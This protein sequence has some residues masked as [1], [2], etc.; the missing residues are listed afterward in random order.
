MRRRHWLACSL[1]AA[2]LP[3]ARPAPADDEPVRRGRALQF[4]RDHGAHLGAA[5]EW[6]YLTG[7]LHGAGDAHFGFQIT[8]FRSRTGLAEGLDSRFAP[9]HLLFAHAALSELRTRRHRHAQRIARWSGDE[10]ATA[11]RA[12]RHDTDLRLGDWTLRRSGERGLSRYQ[13]R[14]GSGGAAGGFELQ[15]E[16]HATQPPL[17]QGDA[18][19]SRKG[20]EEAQASHYLSEPQLQARGALERGGERFGVTGRA[21]LDHEWSDTLMHPEAVGWDWIGMNLDDGAALTAFRLRRADGSSLWAGG[22]HRSAGG[23]LQV[24]APD[25]VRFTPGR[26]WTSPSS[27]ARYALQWQVDTPAGR[28][29]VEALLDAQELDSR[30]GTGTVYW[31]GLAELRTAPQRRVG[32]GYLEMTGYAGRLRL[33][34]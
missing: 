24:F 13:T 30:A 25:S 34:Q 21:W 4:P 23:V 29:E 7:E 1:L 16:L 18:G 5:I 9:R 17:L 22:S 28:F 31:E 6:W 10:A 27:G 19:F 11:A 33:G 32:S 15:L 26:L 2:A 20:P 8:F 3:A 14:F 12:S